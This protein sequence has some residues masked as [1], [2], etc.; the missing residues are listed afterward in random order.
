MKPKKP[1]HKANT[2]IKPPKILYKYANWSNDYHKKLLITPEIYFASPSSFN[3]P[4]DCKARFR[5]GDWSDDEWR[6][7]LRQLLINDPYY[8]GQILEDEIE[9]FITLLHKKPKSIN[10]LD[11]IINENQDLFFSKNVGIFSLSETNAQL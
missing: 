5:Y 10:R 2:L 8:G 11:A 3:D 4:F 1:F 9:R 7:V 6:I